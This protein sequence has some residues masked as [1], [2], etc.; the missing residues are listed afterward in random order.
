MLILCGIVLALGWLV[1]LLIR[2]HGRLLLDYDRL[3]DR[4]AG[5]EQILAQRPDGVDGEIAG[6]RNPTPAGQPSRVAG[7][8]YRTLVLK[9]GSRFEVAID[10]RLI[11]PISR[12]VI[13]G[14]FW[15]LDDFSLLLDLMKPG[16]MVL[17]L[18]GHIG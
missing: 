3:Q 13:G 8:L 9:D 4:L 1:Y 5:V 7:V 17:D 18:G 15:F 14:E 11:D 2:R 10:P 12:A 6:P 16:D